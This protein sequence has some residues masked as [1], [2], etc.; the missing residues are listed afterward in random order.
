M[1][2]ITGSARGANLETLEGEATRP[3]SQRV[4]EA[5]FSMIQFE[6]EGRTVLDLF[7][8]SGQLGLEALSRGAARATFC[9]NSRE[10]VDVVI[11]NAK[12]TRLFD[13]CRIGV[14]DYATAIR[15]MAKREKYNLI[16][17]DPPY[18]MDL[19]P[20]VLRRLAEADVCAPGAIVVCESGKEDVFGGDEALAAKYR[21]LKK[22]R[23]SISYITLLT[24]AVENAEEEVG[25]DRE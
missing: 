3:T 4:K 19:C 16:F 21:V 8:G 2:I 9:D 5:V 7:A 6:I 23:Y 13:R 10:A 18:A 1:R 22:N 17:I 20:E 25:E 15:S 24:P 14:N 12:K 11:R